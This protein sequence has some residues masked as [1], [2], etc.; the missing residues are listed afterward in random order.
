MATDEQVEHLFFTCIIPSMITNLLLSFP[1]PIIVQIP[2]SFLFRT[3]L[4]QR[5]GELPISVLPSYFGRVMSIFSRFFFQVT[6]SC[7]GKLRIVALIS[8]HSFETVEGIRFRVTNGIPVRYRHKKNMLNDF[9][10]E[11]EN[12]QGKLKQLN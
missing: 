12:I 3:F 6:L 8:T 7:C 11:R 9:Q 4:M 1:S 5:M 10:T 2:S